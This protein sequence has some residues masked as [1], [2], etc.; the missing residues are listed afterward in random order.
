M[1]FKMIRC[2]WIFD[3]Q[4]CHTAIAIE[5]VERIREINR[6]EREQADV[7][8]RINGTTQMDSKRFKGLNKT[9]F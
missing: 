4:K 6:L 3:H 9:L 8:T 2:C 7:D 1:D 5:V